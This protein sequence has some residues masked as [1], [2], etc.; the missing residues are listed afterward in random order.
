VISDHPSLVTVPPA[1]SAEPPVPIPRHEI[2]ISAATDNEPHH[3]NLNVRGC[4]YRRNWREQHMEIFIAILLFG[5]AGLII[6]EFFAFLFAIGKSLFGSTPPVRRFTR[7]AELD[8]L[9]FQ[10]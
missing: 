5:G 9:K 4:P 6:W 3:D 1:V 8:Y 7:D 10:K 2:S